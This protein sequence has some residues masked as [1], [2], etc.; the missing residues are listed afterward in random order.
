MRRVRG[1]LEL[2]VTADNAAQPLNQHRNISRD[3]RPARIINH[4]SQVN[5]GV[6]DS[7]SVSYRAVNAKGTYSRIVSGSVRRTPEHAS[8]RDQL[9]W[10][11]VEPPVRVARSMA[12]P[13]PS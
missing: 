11:L 2:V 4:H 7:R 10:Q 12:H 1:R 3:P 9:I 5:R 6:T 8:V 13:R